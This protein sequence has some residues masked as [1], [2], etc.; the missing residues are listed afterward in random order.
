MV[1]FIFSQLDKIS[2]SGMQCK[3][4]KTIIVGCN[5]CNYFCIG[6]ILANTKDRHKCDEFHCYAIMYILVRLTLQYKLGEANR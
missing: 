5:F 2:Y 1:C 4:Y 3:T 6:V